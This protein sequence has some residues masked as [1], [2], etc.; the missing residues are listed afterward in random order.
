MER[1]NIINLTRQ[2][3]HDDVFS[4]LSNKCNGQYA[5][6]VLDRHAAKI[7]GATLSLTDIMERYDIAMLESLSKI[8][9]PI[10]DIP[11]L[12]F[13]EPTIESIS[14][15]V[16]DFSND[17]R[18]PMYK[19]ALLCFTR[20]IPPEGA[21]L[22]KN[23]A[24]L[25]MRVLCAVEVQLDYLP[26]EN[27]VVSLGVSSPLNIYH[28]KGSKLQQRVHTV[29]SRLVTLF[30]SSNERPYICATTNT[31]STGTA[32]TQPSLASQ[33]GVAVNNAMNAYIDGAARANFWYWGDGNLVDNVHGPHG[34]ERRRSTLLIVDRASDV[35]SSVLHEFTYQAMLH[36]LVGHTHSEDSNTMKYTDKKQIERRLKVSNLAQDNEDVF[37][38]RSRHLH[39]SDVSK[40]LHKA[41]E[42]YGASNVLAVLNRTGNNRR[43]LTTKEL[44]D[45]MQ[46]MPEFKE[47]YSKHCG[48][49]YFALLLTKLFKDMNLEK[50]S[51]LEQT[52]V[53]G[54]D[55]DGKKMKYQDELK[56]LLSTI[57]DII[58]KGNKDDEE[59][60]DLDKIDKDAQS[61]WDGL[62][63]K[64]SSSTTTT[65]ET[66][67]GTYHDNI[68]EKERDRMQLITRLLVIFCATHNGI[69]DDEWKKINT[70]IM[71][72]IRTNIKLN[73]RN[74]MLNIAENL[75]RFGLQCNLL[76]A[77]KARGKRDL[78]EVSL[79]SKEAKNNTKIT[80]KKETYLKTLV[81][82][83]LKETSKDEYSTKTIDLNVCAPWVSKENCPKDDDDD[84]EERK[85]K[86][87]RIPRSTR[88]N[89]VPTEL[90]NNE[91]ENSGTSKTKNSG[92][93]G[94][95]GMSSITRFG[96][97]LP[98]IYVYVVGGMT[99]SEI[100]AVYDL[101]AKFNRDILI[102]SSNI[103]TPNIF[104]NYL[105]TDHENDK[106]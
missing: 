103:I 23:C 104:S 29:T 70:L 3:F 2:R 102:I 86:R 10:P 40:Y 73:R 48:H 87:G 65:T 21:S 49:T 30:A 19:A 14:S 45:V 16:A 88:K 94:T 80:R 98:R 96:S 42:N 37:W 9:Q 5:V 11:A 55:E 61:P 53:T 32:D 44:G 31:S 74:Q 25:R 95:I 101:I 69:T 78:I 13:V 85:K 57:E 75:K 84:G 39:I 99:H 64:S 35:V 41:L 22:I 81:H 97:H 15:I 36:D 27:N 91:S 50:I 100:S 72:S 24:A 77:D 46:N 105:L 18:G 58:L 47:T 54:V 43:T 12:Y 63:R 92:G 28:L 67:S 17:K 90:I 68:N 7:M 1:P 62:G 26:L 71:N 89:Y 34:D 93:S 59:Q 82:C 83:M 79:R 33:L 38:E 6:M 51:S 8:R 4:L 66:K 106:D 60:E 52:I 20:S 56:L 76:Q